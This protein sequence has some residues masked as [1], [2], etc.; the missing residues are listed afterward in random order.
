MELEIGRLISLIGQSVSTAQQTLATHAIQAYLAYFQPDGNTA[1]GR[2]P[3]TTELLI[4]LPD[5]TAFKKIAVPLVTLSP[6]NNLELEHVKI[7]LRVSARAD[8]QGAVLVD[9]HAPENA[10]ENA[11]NGLTEMELD[12][13]QQPPAEGIARLVTEINKFL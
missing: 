3:K 9:L 12:F 7:K 13:H 2:T 5:S 6:H 1:N 10:Q 8:E 11:Q 4:P